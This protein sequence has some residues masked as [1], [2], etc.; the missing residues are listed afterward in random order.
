MES[1]RIPQEKVIKASQLKKRQPKMAIADNRPESVM[2]A[3][4]CNII[5]CSGVVQRGEI[6]YEPHEGRIKLEDGPEIGGKKMFFTQAGNHYYV[7]VYGEKGWLGEVAIEAGNPE[8]I[9]LHTHST[10]GGGLAPFM[11]PEVIDKIRKY[12]PNVKH[13]LMA[14]AP[15]A[16][17]KK[18]IEMLSEAFGD[19]SIH[20]RAKREQAQRRSKKSASSVKFALNQWDPAM[21]EEHRLHL[22]AL[23]ER[24][25]PGLNITYDDGNFIGNEIPS[26]PSKVPEEVITMLSG[27]DPMKTGPGINV[28]GAALA[29]LLGKDDADV[30]E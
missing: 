4:L 20:A 13:I 12:L 14:P 3:R 19:A 21:L 15:G 23:A 8:S 9:S 26:L 7:E 27:S 18:V 29:K 24:A 5:Q 22:H 16:A 11:F 10:E 6:E 28:R 25:Y 1:E 17:S 30:L 2:Q